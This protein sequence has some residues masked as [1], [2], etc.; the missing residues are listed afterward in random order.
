M[1]PNRRPDIKSRPRLAKATTGR[2]RPRSMSALVRK[3]LSPPNMSCRRRCRPDHPFQSLR[4]VRCSPCD[5]RRKVRMQPMCPKPGHLK[6]TEVSFIKC[7]YALLSK[8]P[9]SV[10]SMPLA[11]AT[12]N[13]PAWGLQA[14]RWRM[15]ATPAPRFRGPEVR[16]SAGRGSEGQGSGGKQ[17]KLSTLRSPFGLAG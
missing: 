11:G 15:G 2:G 17:S 9:V 6:R 7:L 3:L 13:V 10:R 4:R 8:R 1:I 12:G 5:G 14:A 16:G